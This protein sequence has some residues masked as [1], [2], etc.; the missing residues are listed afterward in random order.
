MSGLQL[1]EIKSSY[2]V[3]A[4]DAIH[5][6]SPVEITKQHKGPIGLHLQGPCKPEDRLNAQFRPTL[7]VKATRLEWIMDGAILYVEISKGKIIHVGQLLGTLRWQTYEQQRM[8]LETSYNI[9][10]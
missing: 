7:N 6:K 9:R 4:N 1:R 2:M 3:Q 8:I 10:F 5:I